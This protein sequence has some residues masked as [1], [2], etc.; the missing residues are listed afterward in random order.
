MSS[1][2]ALPTTSPFPFPS[3]PGALLSTLHAASSSQLLGQPSNPNP[4][5]SSLF[6]PLAPVLGS[7]TVPVPSPAPASPFALPS[8]PSLSGPTP[9]ALGLSPAALTLDP[10]LL[11]YAGGL[12]PPPPGAHMPTGSASGSGSG[13][14][15][16]PARQGQDELASAAARMLARAEEVI[17]DIQAME[18]TV[19][20]SM[21]GARRA[22]GPAGQAGMTRLEALHLEYSQLV[23]ALLNALSSDPLGALPVPLS[24][25]ASA[26]AARAQQGEPE[27]AV[28]PPTESGTAGELGTATE[29][30]TAPALADTPAHAPTD[31]P[32]VPAPPRAPSGAQLADWAEAH[33]AA[34]F[35]RR[36]AVRAAAR[37][38]GDVLRQLQ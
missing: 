34:Q 4:N 15:L 1:P 23:L 5:P 3:S 27:P 18:R 6:A 36:D 32:A 29:S 11:G 38:A 24:Q 14:A 13:P 30:A 21:D 7:L 35:A 17:L 33:A 8:L 2:F 25:A 16:A 19:F 37:A 26:A 31:P 22:P 20:R 9:L 10:S 12:A 28:A